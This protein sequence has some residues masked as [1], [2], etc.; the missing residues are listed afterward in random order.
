MKKETIFALFLGITF[1]V[2]VALLFIFTTK[3]K[4]IDEKKIIAAPTIT[5]SPVNFKTPP[6]EILEPANNSASKKNNITL[7]GKSAKNALL[8]FSSP[9]T[10]RSL[11][12]TSENFEINFPL[13]AGENV[14]KITSYA[15]KNTEEKTLKVYYLE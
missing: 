13:S 6:F 15:E 5:I 2:G 8:I 7:K 11:K 12:T 10:D 9:T 14:I 3:T 4:S 1:G